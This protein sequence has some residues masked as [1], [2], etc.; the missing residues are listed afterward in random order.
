MQAVQQVEDVA[1][2]YVVNSFDFLIEQFV[3]ARSYRNVASGVG[4]CRYR[5]V[6]FVW[7]SKNQ[8]PARET[9][10]FPGACFRG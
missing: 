5:N 6:T 3:L 1:A 4:R 10:P 2:G 8:E 9:R 7:A